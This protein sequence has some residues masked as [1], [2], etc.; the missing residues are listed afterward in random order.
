ML[1][2]PPPAPNGN[3]PVCHTPR[4]GRIQEFEKGG[5]PTLFFSRAPFFRLGF[6][7]GGGHMYKKGGIY[8]KMF[9]KGGGGARAGC[10]PP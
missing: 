5:T 7:R 6:K 8:R 2:P 10:A 4:Q 1:C 9:Q 3:G